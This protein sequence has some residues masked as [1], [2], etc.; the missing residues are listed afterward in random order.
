[1][2]ILLAKRFSCLSDIEIYQLVEK[3][4]YLEGG[5]GNFSSPRESD[6]DT[7]AKSVD[8]DRGRS[9]RKSS[10]GNSPDKGNQD[11]EHMTII[12]NINSL[13]LQGL[14]DLT[15]QDISSL[16]QNI[17]F[18]QF[19]RSAD[20]NG[21]SYTPP[22]L[23]AVIPGSD[24]TNHVAKPEKQRNG[25]S[26]NNTYSHDRLDIDEKHSKEA[27]KQKQRV[28]TR[29][30]AR[31]HVG[32]DSSTD[33]EQ[34]LKTCSHCRATLHEF[35]D[36][37]CHSEREQKHMA[38]S[39]R[40]TTS[41]SNSKDYNLGHE[42]GVTS[43][44]QDMNAPFLE[45]DYESRRKQTWATRGHRVT[46][47]SADD[48][49]SSKRRQWSGSK[50]LPR[51][52]SSLDGD[53]YEVGHKRGQRVQDRRR[54]SSSSSRDDYELNCVRKP[55]NSNHRHATSPS[56]RDDIKPRRKPTR[57]AKPR[58][59]TPPSDSDDSDSDYDVLRHGRHGDRFK[60]VSTRRPKATPSQMTPA[61]I[62]RTYDSWDEKE[63][64]RPKAHNLSTSCC[65]RL[66]STSRHGM[67]NVRNK[68]REYGYEAS[69][70]YEVDTRGRYGGDERAGDGPGYRMWRDV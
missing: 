32:D 47:P 53:D 20:N 39:H 48:G 30:A 60:L 54:S 13:S 23:D 67:S 16:L 36:D 40:C 49:Y 9:S 56:T 45:V 27:S 3:L 24:R 59:V 51:G 5:G 41:S 17:I 12:L 14:Q 8:S 65:T 58:P 66:K 25:T 26:S 35:E 61:Y 43:K 37:N 22:G 2:L 11:Y 57:K 18:R 1:M 15:V 29:H 6:T 64:Q 10:G 62:Q 38:R 7:F 55:K 42:Q 31:L 52:T 21:I 70:I 46:L 63:T 19:Q 28:K 69:D 33:F 50:D 34:R 4:R 44:H 68:G